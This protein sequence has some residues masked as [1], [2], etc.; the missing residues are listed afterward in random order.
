VTSVVVLSLD[1][2][3]AK[4]GRAIIAINN[5]Q[6]PIIL[7]NGLR[8]CR[9]KRLVF[10]GFLLLRVKMRRCDKTACLGTLPPADFAARCLAKCKYV[11]QRKPHLPKGAYRGEIGGR[12]FADVH[13]RGEVMQLLLPAELV[14]TEKN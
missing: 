8:S 2:E 6:V 14:S 12:V 10:I 4:A 5:S 11:R 9:N 7:F 3:H 1:R 13:R